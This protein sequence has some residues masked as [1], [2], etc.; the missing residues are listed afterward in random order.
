MSPELKK[1]A[2]DFIHACAGAFVAAIGISAAQYGGA[3][4]TDIAHYFGSAV[5]GLLGI[6]WMR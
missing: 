6:K 2:H 3:H 4:I 5:G 1:E